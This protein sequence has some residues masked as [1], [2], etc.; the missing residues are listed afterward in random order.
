MD[1]ATSERPIHGL[2]LRALLC[3]VPLV[4]LM[5]LVTV[6]G[7]M[8][9]GSVQIGILQFAPAAVGGLLVLVA[10]TR[11][12][13]WLI[14]RSVLAAQDLFPIYVMMLIAVLMC[15]RGT[16]EKLV[17]PLVHLNYIAT[18][19]NKYM[20]LFA[21]YTP[22]HLVVYDPHGEPRQ[23]ITRDYY[24]GNAHVRWRR[25]I[26]P[27][28]SW[29]GLLS[30]VYTSFMCLSVILR[31]Q[32]ADN[33]KLVFPLTSLPLTILDEAQATPFLHNRLMW[34]GAAIP[35]GIFFVNGLHANI[36]GVPEAKLMWDL[37]SFLTT[38]PWNGI[39]YTQINLSLAAVGFFYFLS[40]DLLLSLWFFFVLTR[41]ED[42]AATMM[43]FQ[44][45][46]MPQYP[47]RLFVGY[48]VAGAYAV[49]VIYLLYTGWPH[50]SR[51]L[52]SAWS[53]VTDL[54]PSGGDDEVLPY[55]LA[56]VGLLA[57]FLGA[58]AWCYFTGLDL[59]LAFVELGVYVFMVALVL[60]RGVA[61]AGLLQT[62]ASFRPIDLIKLFRPQWSLGPRNLTMMAML[63]TVLTR[64]LRGLL[65]STFLDQQKMAKELR[66]RP[67]A[68][69]VPVVLAIGTALAAGCYYFITIS[70]TLGHVTLYGYPQVNAGWQFE[71]AATAMQQQLPSP[72]GAVPSFIA[73]VILC[74][75]LVALRTL[76]VWWPLHPL[77]YAVSGSWTL[78]VFWFPALI[79]WIVKSFILRSGGMKL[80][81]RAMPFFLGLILGTFAAAFFWTMLVVIGRYGGVLIQAP[82][83]GFD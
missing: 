72:A 49:L 45:T 83:M 60:S 6:Y 41:F 78:I 18:D 61:E 46:A 26:G 81:R 1:V 8:V 30:L 9:V 44:P 53:R 12:V 4:V 42:I 68:L 37:N 32:W 23:R 73:G 47:C 34:L 13:R 17:P 57:S 10:A 65:L 55:S 80:Y 66:Y 77:G 50:Y 16:I 79:T 20:E 27:I 59:W 39:Y 67:R 25:W 70:H 48:Q 22:K 62:E 63:D 14:R 3:G 28:L 43:G 69:V 7:D 24:E 21:D 31:R 15:S 82:N 29:A 33:E 75:A 11:M 19:E 64:D 51:V 38:R 71:E 52:R 2:R 35:A 36:P 74:G 76:V 54:G 58:V 40:S 5:S 56:V